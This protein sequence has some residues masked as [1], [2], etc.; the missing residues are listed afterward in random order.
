M[1]PAAALGLGSELGLALVPELVLVVGLWLALVAGVAVGLL[2]AAGLVAPSPIAR[3]ASQP[4][5][6]RITT[7]AVTTTAQTVRVSRRLL[8]KPECNPHT[9]PEQQRAATANVHPF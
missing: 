6:A 5:A 2:A 8:T 9:S 7:N 4:T 3:G 1:L